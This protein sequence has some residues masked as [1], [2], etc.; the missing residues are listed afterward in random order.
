MK[1]KKKDGK[2]RSRRIGR[3]IFY[4]ILLVVLTANAAPCFS[5]PKINLP[6]TDFAI[7]YCKIDPE[8]CRLLNRAGPGSN[9]E[10]RGAATHGEQFHTKAISVTNNETGKCQ[11]MCGSANWTRRNIQNFNMEA[12]FYIENAPGFVQEYIVFF[13]SLW[14]NANDLIFTQDYERFAIEGWELL[15]KKVLYRIQ[16]NTGASTF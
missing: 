8:R 15:W 6:G 11:F 3:L 10:I 12:C 1:K 9:L 2:N 13:N 14:N 4:G 5:L 16:E 7:A